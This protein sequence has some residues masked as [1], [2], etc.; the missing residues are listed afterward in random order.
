MSISFDDLIVK[1]DTLIS[2]Q[3][4]APSTLMQYRWAWAQFQSFCSDDGNPILTD[5]VVDRYLGFVVSEHRAGRFKDWK[6]KLLRKSV[7]V[8]W[9][10]NPEKWTQ[11]CVLS[12]SNI[13][14]RRAIGLEVNRCPI[15]QSRMPTPRVIPSDPPEHLTTTLIRALPP[16]RSLQRLPLQS[17]VGR[18][19]Q[20]IIGTRPDPSHRL[21]HTQAP[22]RGLEYRRRILTAM[23][24]VKYRTFKSFPTVCCIV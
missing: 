23:V 17:R 20:G 21:N 15:S 12:D 3:G 6:A 5:E 13:N 10:V 2:A 24:R 16:L 11:Q 8:L 19:R 1:T 18:L 7:L 4:S 14:H 9:G 22:T